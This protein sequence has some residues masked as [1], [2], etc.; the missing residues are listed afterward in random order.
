MTVYSLYGM[1]LYEAPCEIVPCIRLSYE[2]LSLQCTLLI[3][4]LH[5]TAKFRY[6][7]FFFSRHEPLTALV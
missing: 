1:I 7:W 4:G 5:V 2:I 6:T 3:S